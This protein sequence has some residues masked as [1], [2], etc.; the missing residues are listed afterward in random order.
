MCGYDRK[1]MS[2]ITMADLSDCHEVVWWSAMDMLVCLYQDCK[3]L[4]INCATSS[5]VGEFE[6]A[7]KVKSGR[8]SSGNVYLLWVDNKASK[9]LSS[10]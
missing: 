9:A 4:M 1:T 3:V 7:G 2:Q 5:V 8:V 6:F 10:F